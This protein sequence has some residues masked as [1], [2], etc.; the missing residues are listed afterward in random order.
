MPVQSK[1]GN[2]KGIKIC[3]KNTIIREF[4]N[5]KKHQF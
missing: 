2:R 5:V 4:Y 3:F 1:I